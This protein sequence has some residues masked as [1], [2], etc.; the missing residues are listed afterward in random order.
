VK[1]V[2]I[3]AVQVELIVVDDERAA[4]HAAGELLAETAR[5]GG[6]IALSGGKTPEHAYR[7]A[8]RLQPDWSGVELWWGDERCVPPDDDRSNYLLAK[9]TLLDGLRTPPHDV[10]RIR[11]ELDPEEAAAEYDAAL[12]G[13]RLDL[14]LLGI[15]P[16]GHAASLFP[17]A[18]GLGEE[19]RLAIVA[20]PGLDPKVDRVTM[21]PPMLRNADLV[22][23]LVA[24][25]EKA[26]AAA[27][28]FAGPESRAT[29]AS[30]IRSAGGR[31]VAIVD[32][33]AASLLE[34]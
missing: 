12:R 18:P 26:E 8:A 31:T 29:P 14:N 10:H 33:A 25:E 20:K 24:G 34:R 27:R 4:A 11:G 5:T 17:C 32:R 22:L 6:D 28:A 15:G 2:T 16:D 9:R 30:L 7:T 3:A 23:F 19:E 21:T 1:P 13:V